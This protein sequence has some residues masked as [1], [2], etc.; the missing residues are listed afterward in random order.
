MKRRSRKIVA[1]C[2]VL[3]L[4]GA[5]TWLF[6]ASCGTNDADTNQPAGLVRIRGDVVKPLSPGVMVPLDLTFTNPRDV[7]VSITRLTVVLAGVSAPSSDGTHVCTVGDFVVDQAPT[8]LRITLAPEATNT[9][10]SLGFP[11]RM[12]PCMG[13]LDRPVNQDGCKGASVSLTYTATGG[14]R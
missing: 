12:W 7:D 2:S 3:V 14:T 1:S 9:L 13:M 10:S 6:L 5:A 8:E 4:S 11:S